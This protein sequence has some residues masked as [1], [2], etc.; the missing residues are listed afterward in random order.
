MGK[1]QPSKA[2]RLRAALVEFGAPLKNIAA[3]DFATPGTGL[4][5]GLPP[6]RIDILTVVSGLS[7]D[8]AWQ[9]RVEGQLYDL[10]VYVIGAEDLVRNK[11]ASG[12]DKDLQDVKRLIKKY[13]DT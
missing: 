4:H 8:D 3:E 2:G 11:R 7:F 5:I 13:P 1:A 6:G 12:R 9:N 10:P